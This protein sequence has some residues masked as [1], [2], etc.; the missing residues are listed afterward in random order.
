METETKIEPHRITKPIQLLAVWFSALVLLDTAFLVAARNI[1]TPLWIAP[2]LVV[3]AVVFVPIF[4]VAAFLM[5][6]LFRPQLQ[7]DSHY[8]E[9]LK[10]RE[11]MFNNFTPENKVATKTPPTRKGLIAA[12]NE[13]PLQDETDARRKAFYISQYGLFLVH[14][15]RPSRTPGQVADIIIWLQQHREGPLTRGQV[16]KVEYHLGSK[17]FDRPPVKT[18]A[19]DAFRIE[20]SAY[21][22]MLCLARVFVRGISE[23][24]ELTRYADFDEMPEQQG[25]GYSPPAMRSSP[26]QNVQPNKQI[27]DGNGRRE[28]RGQN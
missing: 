27:G 18:N 20:V 9:W 6:T 26:P 1:A 7:D 10:R 17:F 8:S 12:A 15:W 5:Q 25:G 3:S 16:E 4:L 21:A 23:P 22:P 19:A 13:K 2:L 28:C 24:I 11:K 14:D